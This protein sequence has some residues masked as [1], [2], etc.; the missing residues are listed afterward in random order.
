MEVIVCSTDGDTD[1]FSIVNG[2]LQG[3]TSGPFLFIISLDYVL[4]LS[5][6][7]MK[8]NGFILKKSKKQIISFRNVQL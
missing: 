7:L 8:E 5:L 3:N 1:F 6:D 4:Q 2:V